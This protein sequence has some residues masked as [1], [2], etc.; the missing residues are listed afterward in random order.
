MSG[1]ECGAKRMR[2]WMEEGGW[3]I[4]DE[5]EIDGGRKLMKLEN[6]EVDDDDEV[7]PKRL[8]SVVKSNRQLVIQHK[9]EY[10]TNK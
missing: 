3:R 1:K 6:E 8:R 2:W 5:D 9:A 7:L 4:K 10:T